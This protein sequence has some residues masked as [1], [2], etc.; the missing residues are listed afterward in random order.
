MKNTYKFDFKT[1]EFVMKSG[2]P[3]VLSGLDALKMWLE[4]CLRTQLGRYSIYSGTGY[5][6]NIE[7]L[8]VGNTYGVD[9]AK[10]ELQREIETALLKHDDINSLTDFSLA[11][12]GDTL[13]VSFTLATAYGEDEEVITL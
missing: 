3:V 10:S 4:K 6:A 5:G 11:R 12:S 13:T 8:V 2:S 7:D 1:G 9:F